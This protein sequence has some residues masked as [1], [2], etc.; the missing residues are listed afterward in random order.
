[1][2]FTLGIGSAT[3]D[4]G[5][6]ITLFA[7]QFPKVPRWKITTAL[8]IGAF[9]VGLVYVTPVNSATLCFLRM[10]STALGYL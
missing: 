5:A 2:L 10:I 6:V 7:D 1:M 9:L 8:C 4:A 3:A